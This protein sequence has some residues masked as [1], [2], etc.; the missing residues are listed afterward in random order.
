MNRFLLFCLH[1]TLALSPLQVLAQDTAFETVPNCGVQSVINFARY[2]G[3]THATPAKL[4]KP[5]KS[6]P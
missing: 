1:A 3:K 6:K 4:S 2:S 5:L